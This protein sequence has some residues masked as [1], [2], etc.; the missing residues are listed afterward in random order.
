MEGQQNSWIG[1]TLSGRY[2]ILE[3]IGQGGMGIV[4]KARQISVDRLVA[5]KMMHAKASR[6][7][8]SVDRFHSEARA[9]SKLAHPNTIRLYDF[10]QTT[11]GNLYMVMELLEGRD[12]RRVI[13]EEAPLPAPR[14]LRILM[15]CAASLAE[16]H[17]AG[18]IHRDIKPENIFLLDIPG[19]TDFVKLLD[20]SIA[21]IADSEMTAAGTIYGT[22]QYM[23]PEQASGKPIDA[24]SDVYSLGIVAYAMLSNTLPF[25]HSDPF[26][27]LKMHKNDPVPPLP[28]FV[29]DM[30]QKVVL[31]CLQK[32]P[33]KRPASALALLEACKVWLTTLDPSLD[34]ASDPVLK[35]T[36][37]TPGPPASMPKDLHSLADGAVEYQ[38]SVSKQKTMLSASG[39]QRLASRVAAPVRSAEPRSTGAHDSV[40][41]TQVHA[42][43]VRGNDNDKPTV[44]Y[45][46]SNPVGAASPGGVAR[47]SQPEPQAAS[48]PGPE[49]RQ[50]DTPTATNRPQSTTGP[51][52]PVAA[53]AAA[54]PV[55]SAL[56]SSAPAAGPAPSSEA[57]PA[58]PLPYSE[59][60]AHVRSAERPMAQMTAPTPHPIPQQSSTAAFLLACLLVAVTF[61]LGGYYITSALR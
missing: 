23:S 20:F 8:K 53:P 54:Q 29:P 58:K 45:P 36:L 31:G 12:L 25:H 5:V 28:D 32:E 50:P 38:G 61:G 15:Q 16:A 33:A 14:V 52:P 2:E 49:A 19:A 57:P 24:R 44:V 4:F 34:L 59:P 42:P 51:I 39:S 43:S 6:S 1:R 56:A 18:I 3:M 7:Q 9:C 13:A 60:P 26:T 46:S 41:A 10:G 17:A 40:M 21:K 35:N 11:L 48:T 37:V 27:V 55:S 22:P 47:P 30:V